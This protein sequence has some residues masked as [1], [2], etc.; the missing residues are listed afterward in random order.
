MFNSFLWTGGFIRA[1]VLEGKMIERLLNVKGMIRTG[2][3]KAKRCLT[4][5]NLLRKRIKRGSK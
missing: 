2:N 1:K 5:F 4:S 3:S